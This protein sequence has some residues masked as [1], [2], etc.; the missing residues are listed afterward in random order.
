M[1]PMPEHASC[2]RAHRSR[3]LCTALRG[4]ADY[5]GVS[6]VRS[7]SAKRKRGSANEVAVFRG[8]VVCGSTLPRSIARLSIVNPTSAV[9]QLAQKRIFNIPL[10]FLKENKFYGNDF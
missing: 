1:K 4:C 2:A 8:T 6:E 9:Q 5:I 10:T 3:S 7:C